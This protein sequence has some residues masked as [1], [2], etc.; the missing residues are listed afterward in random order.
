VGVEL[1]VGVAELEE[2]LALCAMGPFPAWLWLVET[3]T[4]CSARYRFLNGLGTV[5]GGG[6]G[7][8]LVTACGIIFPPSRLRAR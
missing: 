3:M 7:C 5:E 6:A 1:G 8:P 2:G 4:L